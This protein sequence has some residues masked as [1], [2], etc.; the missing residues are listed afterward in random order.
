MIGHGLGASGAMESVACIKSIET[1]IVHPTINL[2]DPDPLCD[3]DYVPHIARDHRQQYV[4]S[5]SFAFGGQNAALVMRS[6]RTST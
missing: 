6:G 5:S 4:L 1:G 3:L 2:D